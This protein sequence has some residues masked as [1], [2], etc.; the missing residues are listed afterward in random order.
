MRIGGLILLACNDR[1]E[2]SK[3]RCCSVF[4]GSRDR[5]WAVPY[6]SLLR[7]KREG[8]HGV[9]GSE[10]AID[11]R[12]EPELEPEEQ[13]EARPVSGRARRVRLPEALEIGEV[14]EAATA[15]L[16]GKDDGARRCRPGA[17]KPCVVR[18]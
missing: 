13:P 6:S 10:R 4:G 15:R 18:D 1:N 8:R 17:T 9:V 3:A 5:S 7:H 11:K 12:P 14:E 16:L 2:G